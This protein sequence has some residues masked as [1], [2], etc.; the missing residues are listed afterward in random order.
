MYNEKL[1]YIINHRGVILGLEQEHKEY[2]DQVRV[3]EKYLQV[4][5]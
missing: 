4:N 3:L 5:F 2:M 1:G